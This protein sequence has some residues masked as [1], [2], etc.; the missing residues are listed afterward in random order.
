MGSS[1]FH[2]AM[3][4]LL[5]IIV[6]SPSKSYIFLSFFKMW[7]GII[8]FGVSNGFVLLPVLL[9]N[10]GP[11]PDVSSHEEAEGDLEVNHFEI[12]PLKSEEKE[13]S[14]EN[15]IGKIIDEANNS[16]PGSTSSFGVGNKVGEKP[17]MQSQ[18]SVAETVP[19]EG[20]DR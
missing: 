1:V 10:F 16:K 7:F 13:K 18:V 6:L 14:I 4:T 12:V 5:A 3:S 11:L 8:V 15:E 20:S 2:G 9:S 17:T 19:I